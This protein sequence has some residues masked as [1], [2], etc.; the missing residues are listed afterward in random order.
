VLLLVS[1][2]YRVTAH[3]EVALP[4]RL[5]ALLARAAQAS[6]LA[7]LRGKWA[8]LVGIDTADDTATQARQRNVDGIVYRQMML[9]PLQRFCIDAGIAVA[10]STILAAP[11]GHSSEA[12]GPEQAA[13]LG[14]L[15]QRAYAQAR[16]MIPHAL[17]STQ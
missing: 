1:P 15:A 4:M 7:Q 10:G 2:L 6:M 8:V 3:Q 5:T 16:Q 9:A 11:E 12:L 17:P 13:T 14:T